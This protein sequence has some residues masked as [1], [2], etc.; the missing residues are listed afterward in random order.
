MPAIAIMMPNPT[1]TLGRA[2]GAGPPPAGI[3]AT[4]FETLGR[5]AQKRPNGEEIG[6]IGIVL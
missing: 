6:Q 2:A 5:M 3:S 1:Y 4:G